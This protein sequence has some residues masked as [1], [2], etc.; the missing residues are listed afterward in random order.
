[1]LESRPRP[2]TKTSQKAAVRTPQTYAESL[3]ASLAGYAR[4]DRRF[5]AF[6]KHRVRDKLVSAHGREN[7][8]QN[9]GHLKLIM[10]AT[11][12]QAE[13]RTD[14]LIRCIR[15]QAIPG[16]KAAQECLEMLV[17]QQDDPRLKQIVVGV[18]ATSVPGV[19]V[20]RLHKKVSMT[21]IVNQDNL[22]ASQ[23]ELAQKATKASHQV[24]L[25]ALE[26]AGGNLG[27]LEPEIGDWFFAEKD[28]VFYQAAGKEISR[29]EAELRALGVPYSLS[30]KDDHV[31]LLAVSPAANNAGMQELWEIEPWHG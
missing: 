6:L 4:Q 21:I 5:Y 8:W 30:Q 13:R 10:P 18:A 22:P 16:A 26:N 3:A 15:F 27:E 28:V 31:G 2:A 12:H 9:A 17:S 20:G 14:W 7:A 29:L 11:R 19:T 23:T 1:M 25:S 24:L